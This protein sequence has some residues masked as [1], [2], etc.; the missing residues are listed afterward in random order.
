[1]TSYI[2]SPIINFLYHLSLLNSLLNKP[3]STSVF[4][5]RDCVVVV[6]KKIQNNL[7]LNLK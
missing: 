3:K 4:K 5:H 6:Y 7:F 2:D 1:M